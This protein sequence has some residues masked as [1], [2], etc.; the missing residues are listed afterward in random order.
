MRARRPA[1]PRTHVG[2]GNGESSRPASVRIGRSIRTG[3]FV[4]LAQGRAR[5]PGDTTAAPLRTAGGTSTTARGSTSTGQRRG[6]LI[7]SG[8]TSWAFTRTRGSGQSLTA[9]RVV[10]TRTRNPAG[11][12]YGSRQTREI[13]PEADT[14]T[15]KGRPTRRSS[16]A[17]GR[18]G[19]HPPNPALEGRAAGLPTDAALHEGH[20]QPAPLV[21]PAAPPPRAS[22][23]PS[24]S[25]GSPP[26]TPSRGRVL[27]GVR[28]WGR[29]ERS[30]RGSRVQTPGSSM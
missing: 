10:P 9:E 1:G 27:D 25:A 30:P 28:C 16:S 20:D 29:P 2:G 21:L 4:K 18:C 6:P 14:S 17:R 7:A 23:S 11:L 26:A 8:D 5:A 3:P 15:S 12:W 19:P 13:S 24:T 22:T